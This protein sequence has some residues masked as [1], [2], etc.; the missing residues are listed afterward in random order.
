MFGR[1]IPGW[2]R[3]QCETAPSKKGVFCCHLMCLGT[4]LEATS[5][6]HPDLGTLGC[7]EAPCI[8]FLW[9]A[10]T[11]STWTSC[12]QATWL[13]RW[14]RLKHKIYNKKPTDILVLTAKASEQRAWLSVWVV[15]LLIEMGYQTNQCLSAW[16]CSCLEEI[17]WWLSPAAH[18][19]CT[20]T[21]LL[22][23]TTPPLASNSVKAK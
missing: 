23:L 1:Q 9:T 16:D 19:F 3:W 17:F 21:L 18:A 6:H 12:T 2:R 15:N 8:R 5:F 11:P 22:S 20:R 13:A 7:Y 10:G 4:Q 14:F